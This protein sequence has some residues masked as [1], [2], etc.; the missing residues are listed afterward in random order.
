[1]CSAPPARLNSEFNLHPPLVTVEW[2]DNDAEMAV[3]HALLDTDLVLGPSHELER[4][5]R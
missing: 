1:M 2:E 5:D 3:L 4:R